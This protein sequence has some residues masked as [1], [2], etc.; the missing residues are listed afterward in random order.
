[1]IP[2]IIITIY[3]FADKELGLAHFLQPAKIASFFSKTADTHPDISTTDSALLSVSDSLITDTTAQRI[4]LFGDSMVEGLSKR[5]RNYAA[6]NNHELLNVIWYSSST[7]IWAQSDTLSH[8]IR[9]FEPTYVMLCLGGNELSIRDIDK[10][11]V[12]IKTIIK[13]I[14]DRPYLWIGPPNWKEDTG[15]NELIKKNVG[16][17]RYFPSKR[18]SF[19]R[20]EDGAHPTLA[21]SYQWMDSVAVWMADSA[22]YRIRMAYPQQDEQ[23]GRTVTL[24]PLK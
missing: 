4:L 13:N 2:L 11:E 16:T 22:S 18:L 19:Q 9:K 12:Y 15:I 1:L 10:R 5:L 20:K 7:K 8:F 23:S 6:D 24:F 3:S 14:G 17:G 21:S